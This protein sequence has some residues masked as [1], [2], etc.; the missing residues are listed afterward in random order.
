MATIVERGGRYM[1]RVRRGGQTAAKTFSLKKDAQAWARRTEADMEAGRWVAPT[2]TAGPARQVIPTLADALGEYRTS[3]AAKMKGA[4]EYG[5]RID[6]LCAASFASKPIDEVLPFDLAQWRDQQLKQHKPGTV[7]RKL[8]LL[9]GVLS[10]AMKE[11]GWLSVN[12]LS[13][14][15][16]P[17]VSDAR[18][19]TL[20]ELEWQW[21]MHAANSSPA[22][23]LP[24][25]LTILARSAMR[26]SELFSLERG[27]V[28]YEG[29][30]AMLKDTKN[31]DARAVP[32]D[33]QA[34]EA[35]RA[36]DKMAEAQRASQLLPVGVVGSVSTRFKATV[37]RARSAYLAD[38]KEKDV[39][40]VEGFLSDIRLH[41]LRHQAISMWAS[42][43]ALT[44]PELMAVSGHKTPRMLVRYSHISATALAQKLDRLVS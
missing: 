40:A 37:R 4:K 17:R 26:R 27:A 41:D 33:P 14:V 21:L 38:C 43:G 6:E 22:R 12:P 39:D 18:S 20:T 35:L 11:R 44:L 25:A 31:G 13:L 28:D 42:T 36:L 19:R 32:L 9:S 29:R 10:W 2:T 23:W 30:T 3:V 16:K 24:H 1:A 15:R 34:L 7:T 5:Y 8:G